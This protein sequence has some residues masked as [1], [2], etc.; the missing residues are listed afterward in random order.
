MR[1]FGSTLGDAAA[2]A[3]FLAVPPGED[4]T[5]ERRLRLA[6]EQR[7]AGGA[8]L[9]A[10]QNAAMRKVAGRRHRPAGAGA[11]AVGAPRDRVAGGAGRRSRRRRQGPPLLLHPTRRQAEP[12][13]AVRARRGRRHGPRPGRRERRSPRRHPGARLVVPVRGRQAGRLRRLRQRRREVDPARARRGHRQRSARRHPPHPRLLGGLAARRRGL[14]LHPL[15]ASARCPPARR[16]TT[17]ASSSTG[18]ATTRPRTARSS[19]RA[20]ISTTGPAST[21]RPTAAGWSSRSAGL[22]QERDLPA[23]TPGRRRAALPRRHRRGGAVPGRRGAGRSHLRADQRGGAARPAVRRRSRRKPARER[24]QRDHPREPRDAGGRRLVRGELAALLPEGRRLAR[25]RCYSRRRA[26]AARWPCPALGTVAASPARATATSCSTASP[27]SSR[28]TGV[29]RSTTAAT[30]GRGLA[31]AGGADRSARVRGGAGP[32][33]RRRTGPGCRCSWST[34]RGWCAT[35]TRPPLLYGY[36]GF[37]ISCSRLVAVGD[38]RFSRPAAST[39]WPTCAA[40]ASTARPG[41][42]PACSATSRTC[43]TTSSPRPST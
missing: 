30:A 3:S 38:A 7:R 10:T 32:R 39:R 18:W 21:S 14:L 34:A 24:W 27:R 16:P 8:A 17:A 2:R 5:R 9:D 37:N 28:P 31:T 36:G 6:G 25:A 26:Q 13:G 40:A 1:R 35:A 4:L 41:T 33:T 23:S 22:G 42:R 11:A 20:A 43:S 19:A 15:P 12:A 29:F